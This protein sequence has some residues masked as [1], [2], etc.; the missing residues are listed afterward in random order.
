MQCTKLQP[1]AHSDRCRDCSHESGDRDSFVT[2]K[3]GFRR[4]GLLLIVLPLGSL[5]A[6]ADGVP[7]YKEGPGSRPQAA[8]RKGFAKLRQSGALVLTKANVNEQMKRTSCSVGIAPPTKAK[9]D[10]RELWRRARA[11]HLRLGWFYRCE[12]CDRWHIDLAGGYAIS[13]SVC[14]TCAHVVKPLAMKEGFMVAADDDDQVFAVAEVLACN[15]ATDVA[16]LRLATDKLKPLPLGSDVVP[17]DEIACFS[18]PDG[19]RGFFSQGHVN[20]FVQRPFLLKQEVEQLTADGFKLDGHPIWMEVSSE[21]APGSSGSAILD[22]CGNAVAHVSEIETV[23]DD[24]E[25][26]P[27]DEAAPKG[28]SASTAPLEPA[29]TSIVFHDAICA[30]EVLALIKK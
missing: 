5:L 1:P 30:S 2:V 3:A 24:P 12:E 13:A 21:W 29:G 26:E 11:A 10:N 15:H 25:P 16:I 27:A 28:K 8:I 17:G 19:R 14:A 22:A 7:I 23:L 20:R 4:L 6:Q 18:E 9:L